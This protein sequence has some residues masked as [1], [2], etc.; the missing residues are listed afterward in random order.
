MGMP[1]CRFSD[2]TEHGGVI[3]LGF[4]QVLIGDLPAS[5]ITDMHT[6]PMFDG[7]VPHVG[8]PFI[9]GSPT[10]L[11]GMMPQS[12]VTDQLVC[13]GPPDMAILGEETG[14]VGMAGAAGAAG[15]SGGVAAM[16]VPVPA[17]PAAPATAGATASSKAEQQPDGTL[18]TS[19]TAPGGSLP[20][21]A[22]TEPG[23]PD[24]PPETTATFESVQPATVLPATKLYAPVDADSDGGNSFWST[25]PPLPS[26]ADGSPGA[27]ENSVPQPSDW[28]SGTHVLVHTVPPG[29]GVKAWAGK[30]A[31]SSDSSLHL[32][33]PPEAID[34]AATQRFRMPEPPAS[35]RS[36]QP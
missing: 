31:G 20:P 6:C 17:A 4:P 26:A 30:L 16:G 14:L 19:A 10:V 21:L 22:L 11:V 2:Q 18:K 29:P 9:L 34:P 3:I 12:R 35:S 8:G 7:P 5:R 25:S 1:A 24:L 23:W 13:V 27:S 33:S 32:W 28:N 15:A 36:A